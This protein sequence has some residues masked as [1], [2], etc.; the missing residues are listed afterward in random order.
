ML[1]LKGHNIKLVLPQ[2]PAL[3]EIIIIL[4]LMLLNMKAYTD[5]NLAVNKSNRMNHNIVVHLSNAED[6]HE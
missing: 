2:Y 3:Y 6:D 1:N 4:N 5:K